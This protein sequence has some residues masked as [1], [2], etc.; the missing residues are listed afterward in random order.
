MVPVPSTIAVRG[1]AR[2]GD[3]IPFD[4]LD[5]RGRAVLSEGSLWISP[6]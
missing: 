5:A 4:A 3:R 1:F 6:P 2:H